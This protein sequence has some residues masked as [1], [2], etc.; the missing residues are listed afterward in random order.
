[1]ENLGQKNNHSESV[2]LGVILEAML[3]I[4]L[5]QKTAVG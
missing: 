1:M 5:I 3:R 4:D 2:L